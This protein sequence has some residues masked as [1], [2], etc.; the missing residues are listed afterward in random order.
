MGTIRT[1]IKHCVLLTTNTDKSCIIAVFKHLYFSIVKLLQSEM[2]SDFK[3]VLISKDRAIL[4][5]KSAIKDR[6]LI[7]DEYERF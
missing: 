5:Q 1:E 6:G 3:R 4:R 7:W 2:F